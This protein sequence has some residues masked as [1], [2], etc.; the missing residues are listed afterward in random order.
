MIPKEVLVP[1]GEEQ[2]ERRSLM[3]D[4]SASCVSILL[5]SGKVKGIS[6][7]GKE[8]FPFPTA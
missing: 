4:V 3:Y 2:Q 5:L 8:S 7:F 6:L 1:K